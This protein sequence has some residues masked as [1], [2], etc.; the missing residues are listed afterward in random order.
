MESRGLCKGKIMTTTPHILAFGGSLRSDSFN[1]KIAALAAEGAREAGAE[2][3]VIELRDYPLPV[4]DQDLEAASGMPA[5]AKKLKELFL[6]SNGLIIA[7]P[8]YNSSLSAA[9]KNAIDWISRAESDDEPPIAALAGK[10][11]L[12][13]SASPG[14]LGGLRG[15]VHLRSIL[16]NLGIIVLPDQIAI[17]TAH[18][19]IKADG[20]LGDTK[21]SNKVKQLGTKLTNHLKKMLA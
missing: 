18:E 16:G 15:L 20:T 9:L 8:E 14:G 4:F 17:P 19:V 1:Q 5:E 10:T 3:T 13:L 7:S 21:Q 6:K 2:V 11:A 12:L